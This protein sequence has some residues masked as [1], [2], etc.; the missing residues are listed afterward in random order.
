MYK[1][2]R[3]Q[4]FQCDITSMDL[5]SEVKGGVDLVTMIFVLSA[6]HPDKMLQA[7]RNIYTVSI[8]SSNY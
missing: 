8:Q 1:L 6:I 7:L 5:T 3:C 2:G 4:A